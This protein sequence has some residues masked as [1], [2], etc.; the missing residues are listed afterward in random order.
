MM[1]H[2]CYGNAMALCSLD[3]K[4]VKEVLNIFKHEDFENVRHLKS[5]R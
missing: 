1:E 5:F 4:E 2:F 3:K